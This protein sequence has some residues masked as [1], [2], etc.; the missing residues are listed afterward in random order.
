MLPAVLDALDE[1]LD[2]GRLPNALSILL[3][4]LNVLCIPVS[5]ARHAP[6]SSGNTHTHLRQAET[7]EMTKSHR[8]HHRGHHVRQRLCVC[9]CV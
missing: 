3:V 5:P 2:A 7:T 6:P 9:V 1:L 8:G 4:S